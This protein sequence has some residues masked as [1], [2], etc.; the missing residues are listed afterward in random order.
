MVCRVVS[1]PTFHRCGSGSSPGLGNRIICEL[2]LFDVLFSTMSRKFFSPGSPVFFT[3]GKNLHL[4]CQVQPHEKKRFFLG[5]G[6][7]GGIMSMG[8]LGLG[9]R[10][11]VDKS[12]KHTVLVCLFHF[13]VFSGH[14]RK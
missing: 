2:S 4:L 12:G 9:G 8:F 11:R 1:A 13:W 14:I 5:L 6:G 10:G 3:L 7:R